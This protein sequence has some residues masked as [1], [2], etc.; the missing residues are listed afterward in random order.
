MSKKY[1]VYE[2]EKLTKGKFSKYKLTKDI[3]SGNLKAES[4]TNT[5]L[6][7]GMPKYYVYEADLMAYLD[8]I[9]QREDE[10]MVFVSELD[11]KDTFEEKVKKVISKID[12]FEHYEAFQDLQNRLYKLEG[13]FE[14]DTSDLVMNST[15]EQEKIYNRRKLLKQLQDI[16]DMPECK[17]ARQVIMGK[18]ISLS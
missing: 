7:R 6:G 18:L 10:K 11:F 17:E 13:V 3:E 16:M 12:A 1:T 14:K 9:R 8:T 4:V 2:I 5:R 15:K